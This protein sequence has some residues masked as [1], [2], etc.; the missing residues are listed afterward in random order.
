MHSTFNGMIVPKFRCSNLEKGVSECY[1]YARTAHFKYWR[2]VLVNID[3]FGEAR[4]N[5]A[6][7]MKGTSGVRRKEHLCCL[8]REPKCFRPHLC[9]HGDEP[10]AARTGQHDRL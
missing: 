6:G 9:L 1:V 4:E 7:H 10:S 5:L 2:L 3:S 8:G